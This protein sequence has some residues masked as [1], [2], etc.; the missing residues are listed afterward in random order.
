MVSYVIFGIALILAADSATGLSC[1]NCNSK[2]SVACSWGLASFTYN[3]EECQSAGFL[4]ALV[5]PKCYK[6]EA[7]DSQGNN[8][9][10]RGCQNP[11]AFGCDIIAKTAG[12][13]SDTSGQDLRMSCVTYMA[14]ALRR[15]Q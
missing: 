10:A 14:N 9:I 7:T 3:T 11:P 6:I 2:D 4:N 15:M 5:G 1:Y 8:Y 13:L 12:W